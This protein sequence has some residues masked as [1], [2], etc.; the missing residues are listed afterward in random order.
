MSAASSGIAPP[1]WRTNLAMGAQRARAWG[2]MKF[3]EIR[4]SDGKEH[5]KLEQASALQS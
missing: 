5:S 2:W 4:D 1:Y 3:N